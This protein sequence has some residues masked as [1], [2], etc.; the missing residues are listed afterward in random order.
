MNYS[1]DTLSIFYLI[2][3]KTTTILARLGF[4]L[5]GG[6]CMGSR[7]RVREIKRELART[8]FTLLG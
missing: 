5:M 4:F 1:R 2:Q 8:E 6:K 7:S 3:N